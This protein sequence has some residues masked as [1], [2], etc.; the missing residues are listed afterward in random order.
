MPTS[1]PKRAAK[2]KK[3]KGLE[4]LWA[5]FVV[6]ALVYICSAVAV[7]IFLYLFSD[8]ICQ[9]Q[10][11]VLS[12]KKLL[13]L[14]VENLTMTSGLLQKSR[15]EAKNWF[16]A[17]NSA[18]NQRSNDVNSLMTKLNL[19]N[20][21]SRQNFEK[22]ISTPLDCLKAKSVALTRLSNGKKY[23]FPTLDTRRNWHSAKSYCSQEG[24][25][26]ANLKTQADI[27]VVWNETKRLGQGDSWVSA[28]DFG[29]TGQPEFYWQ[30]GTFLASDSALWWDA[31][32][33]KS[34][35]AEIQ[36]SRDNKLRRYGCSNSQRFICELP[37]EC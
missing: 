31:S 12:D 37:A 9:V 23:L 17:L 30:D 28:R 26:L 35:C 27:D 19:L 5:A 22:I 1:L 21:T 10:E 29:S 34:G 24:L 3:K 13:L 33:K 8:K 32:A 25:H 36:P 2:P 7:N 4:A 20:A 14:V 6:T 16:N 11:N 15:N 18:N